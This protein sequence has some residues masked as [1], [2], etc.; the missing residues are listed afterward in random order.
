MGNFRDSYDM[1]FME[2]FNRE[3]REA[4][5][6]P[7]VVELPEGR[8]QFAVKDVKIIDK[9]NLTVDGLQPDQYYEHTLVIQLKVINDCQDKGALVNKFHGLCLGSVKRIKA[10]LS[11]MGH[12]F[13]GL[14]AL[15]DDIEA[16][17]ML[18]LII[19]GRVTKKTVKDKTYTNIWLDRCSGRLTPEE[20]GM[21]YTPDDDD[22]EMPWR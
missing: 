1:A 7:K 5:L 15:F 17:S 10:D 2:A 9:G 14:D 4:K 8:Y 21:G 22:E 19:D 3:Y 11:A 12:E 13:E 16:G 20:M 18:G 6:E